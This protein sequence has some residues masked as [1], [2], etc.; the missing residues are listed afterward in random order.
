MI[1]TRPIQDMPAGRSDA[2][3]KGYATLGLDFLFT[4]IDHHGFYPMGVK[5]HGLHG[6]HGF[7]PAGLKN[8]LLFTAS[9]A[10]STIRVIRGFG[11]KEF[12]SYFLR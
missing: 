7:H 10:L 3:S 9:N 11:L 8:P 4:G 5:N 6:L 1:L 12:K 2:R